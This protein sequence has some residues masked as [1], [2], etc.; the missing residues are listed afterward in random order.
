MLRSRVTREKHYTRTAH[1]SVWYTIITY[2]LDL[3]P[4]LGLKSKK[5][6]TETER[7]QYHETKVLC[8]LFIDDLNFM[9][10][11]FEA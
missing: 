4:V 10:E 7:K 2:V 8:K 11:L 5:K 9:Y 3:P 6:V 1:R